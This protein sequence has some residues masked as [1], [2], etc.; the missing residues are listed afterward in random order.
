MHLEHKWK[1]INVEKRSD[2]SIWNLLK[3]QKNHKMW[4]FLSCSQSKIGKKT[5]KRCK[6]KIL[7]FYVFVVF[8]RGPNS[9][10]TFF[11][12]YENRLKIVE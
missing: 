10:E 1:H 11:Y 12:V 5:Q 8:F 6:I 9:E 2:Y 3:T 4:L 7:K